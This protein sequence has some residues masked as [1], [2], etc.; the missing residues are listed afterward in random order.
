[1]KLSFKEGLE[2]NLLQI[3]NE[4]IQKKK[5]ESFPPVATPSQVE[6]E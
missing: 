6:D 1:V 2:N 3:I 4:A 5:W